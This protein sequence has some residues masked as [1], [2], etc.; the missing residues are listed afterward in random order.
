MPFPKKIKKPELTSS[1]LIFFT[2]LYFA[3]GLNASFWRYLVNHLE[4]T[5]F[6]MALFALSLPMALAAILYLAF[7]PLIWPGVAK[8]LLM[9]LLVLSSAANY[10][11]WHYGL[12]FDADMIRNFLETNVREASD[13]LTW[14]SAAWVAATG[15]VPALAV[16]AAK[17]R[18]RPPAKEI[19]LRLAAALVC[20]ISLTLIGAA[21]Y[22][23]YTSFGRNHREIRRLIN[24]GNYIYA[25]VRYFQLEAESRRPFA[26]LDPGARLEPLPDPAPTVFILILGEAA[27][28]K[29][30]DLYGYGRPTNPRLSGENILTFQHVTSCGTATAISVPCLFSNL[31]R[32][33][34]NVGEAKFTENIVDLLQNVGY[35]VWW[36]D[37]DDGCKEVCRRVPTE[38]M[39]AKG[40]RSFCDGESC[41][42][43]A[44]L[45][46]LE[47]YLGRVTGD[48]LI[49]LHSRGSHGP[50][51]YQRYPEKFRIFTPTCDTADLQNCSDEAIRYLHG[52]PYNL[53]PAEQKEIPMLMWFSEN[54]LRYDR[55][56]RRCLAQRATKEEFSH[57][58]IFHS[59][60]SLLEVKSRF[61]DRTL[62]IFLPCRLKPE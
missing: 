42:D 57:D 43:E 20:L 28:A 26:D 29:N 50:S 51:Y 36:R 27:R 44:L 37:N 19:L 22:K 61:Y 41:L 11:M 40:D 18:Y 48:T 2:S 3:T 45:A 53:A 55:L 4:I 54:M 49:V 5:N 32:A 39:D 35:Q 23:Q 59:L 58:H 34:F 62:D 16:A 38:Y 25:A 12:F 14:R 47:E 60:L 46:G 7:S 21:T 52:L 8:P 1:K 13:F 24:P 30:F 9:L 15:L 33:D 10:A 17:I 31:A 6:D 56:D